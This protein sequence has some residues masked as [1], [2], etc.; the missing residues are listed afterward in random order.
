MKIQNNKT[1]VAT[2]TISAVVMALLLLSPTTMIPNVS[3]LLNNSNG[4]QGGLMIKNYMPTQLSK[5]DSDKAFQIAMS[6]SDIK[7]KIG[8]K[9]V[10]LMALGFTGNLKTNPGVWYPTLTLNVNNESEIVAVV[11]LSQNKVTQETDGALPA[12]DPALSTTER[13]WAIDYY[14]GT[15]TISG[16]SFTPSTPSYTAN[17]NHNFTAFLVNGAMSGSNDSHLCTKTATDAYWMQ[18]GFWYY[19]NSTGAR[20]AWTD[21]PHGCFGVGT[22]IA[23]NTSH[24]YSFYIWASSNLGKWYVEAYDNTNGATYTTS[25]SGPSNYTMET[26]DHNTSVFFENGNTITTWPNDFSGSVYAT[27]LVQ[28]SGSWVNWDNDAHADDQD[29]GTTH[30]DTTVISGNLKSGNTATWN[31]STFAS[32]YPAEPI[33]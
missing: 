31:L 32:S 15:Y 9:P 13:A 10:T 20:I 30:A 22:G 8:N 17:S 1:K 21:T 14:S 28:K 19:N 27:G 2:I 11:D 33:C 4:D 5:I 12:K 18:T 26:S 7:T 3:A 6:D 25:V 29:C 16:M 23:Y 24:S